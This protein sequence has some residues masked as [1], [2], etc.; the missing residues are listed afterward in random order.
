MQV[1]EDETLV[2]SD[3]QDCR[4]SAAQPCGAGG[5]PGVRKE[6]RCIR[7][8]LESGR[9]PWQYAMSTRLLERAAVVYDTA[10]LGWQ[11]GGTGTGCIAPLRQLW[12]SLRCVV[13]VCGATSGEGTCGYTVRLKTLPFYFV[14]G[15]FARSAPL[16]SGDW[17]YYQLT[18]GGFDTLTV[19]LER[20]A[21][22]GVTPDYRSLAAPNPPPPPPPP[23]PGPAPPGG[24]NSTSGGGGGG[25]ST[26]GGRRRLDDDDDDEDDDEEPAAARGVGAK[27]GRRLA[28][29]ATAYASAVA[30][31]R[32]GENTTAHGLVGSSHSNLASC[33]TLDVWQQRAEVGY[34]VPTSS[35]STFCTDAAIAGPLY[36]GV[37]AHAA[38]NNVTLPPRHW[39]AITIEHIMYDTSELLSGERRLGCLGYGQWRYYRVSTSGV[40]DARLDL[41]IDLPVKAIYAR[42]GARPTHALHDA[43]VEWPLRQLSLTD[44]DVFEPVEWHVAVVLGG[45]AESL[46]LAPPASE[47]TYRLNVTLHS[48]NL[49]LMSYPF[50]T[51]IEL[52]EA[53]VCCGHY[54]DYLVPDLQRS[55]ALRVEVYVHTGSLQAIFLKHESCGRYPDDIGDD[56][57]C[58]GNCEMGWLTTFNEFTLEK[59]YVTSAVVTVP[60]GQVSPDRRAAGDWYISVAG[61]Q[62]GAATYSLVAS[63]VES[64]V[65][66]QFIP[67]DAELE[68]NERCGRFCVVLT[69]GSDEEEEDVEPLGSAAGP[70]RGGAAA[71]GLA[72]AAWLVVSLVVGAALAS[73]VR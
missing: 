26:S 51:Q 28:S 66:T 2:L 23:S 18:L 62:D 12:L 37:Y 63:L 61:P 41:A 19:N 71:G 48:S 11:Q 45:G 15:D 10:S 52:P 24:D 31:T 33:P 5:D 70:R 36:I 67:L 30:A 6:C 27:L 25:N 68:A 7:T 55:I 14:Q 8:D 20:L 59:S 22:R 53:F 13:D 29:A 3:Y 32:L 46:A 73:S 42:R 17:H 65:V 54:H 57:G 34:D 4:N 1:Y 69:G 21:D 47:G 39:Y 58:V 16:A 44:C 40:N 38:V 43:L 35:A 49:T 64:P 50:N 60:M 56:E 9:P 72:R